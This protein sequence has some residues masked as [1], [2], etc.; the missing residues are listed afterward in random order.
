MSE[1]TQDQ[2][3]AS[4]KVEKRTI[5]GEIR[6]YLKDIAAHW[7]RWSSSIPTPPGTR[8]GGPPTGSSTPRTRSFAAT[9]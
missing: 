5:G 3:E 8:R 9:P 4:D 7:R 6:Y 2:L 1:P